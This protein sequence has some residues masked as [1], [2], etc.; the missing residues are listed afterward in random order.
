MFILQNFI[1]YLDTSNS[2]TLVCTTFSSF[3]YANILTYAWS[4]KMCTSS[5]GFIY[6][7]NLSL[8]L[9]LMTWPFIFLFVLQIHF[10]RLLSHSLDIKSKTRKTNRLRPRLFLLWITWLIQIIMTLWHCWQWKIPQVYNHPLW[11]WI[12]LK[13]IQ[14][15][16]Y[17]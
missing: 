4:E 1:M 3:K 17:I 9:Q 2:S 11:I 8:R 5:T 16:C 13:L 14:E 12:K 15:P 6:L 7:N 10:S